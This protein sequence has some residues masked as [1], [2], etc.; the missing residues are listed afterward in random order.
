MARKDVST[1][2][3]LKAAII[4]ANGDDIYI[5]AD[6]DASDYPITEPIKPAA[7]NS[8][9]VYGQ[10]HTIYNITNVLTSNT[11]CFT[12]PG[13]GSVCTWND[14][15]FNNI[16][17]TNRGCIITTPANVSNHTTT[18]TNCTFQGQW[19]ALFGRG[20]YERCVVNGTGSLTLQ[21]SNADQNDFVLN[22]SYVKLKNKRSDGYYTY[23]CTKLTNCFFTGS[24][25]TTGTGADSG[26]FGA[27][28]FT[29]SNC[30]FNINISSDTAI[31]YKWTSSTAA[32]FGP[33]SEADICLYNSDKLQNVTLT[34]TSQYLRE[35][36]D[37]DLKNAS[38]VSAA[39]FPIIV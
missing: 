33:P 30:I 6:M 16:F 25:D 27:S 31:R 15:N 37:S 36:S 29:P 17:I 4:N 12:N 20:T 35:I 3:A 13:G 21:I 38:A 34:P 19:V 14:V 22:N 1:F 28:R 8:Y 39:G 11:H 23:Y 18:V 10:G 24:I 26:I 9:N 5:N 7:G 2:T 32:S